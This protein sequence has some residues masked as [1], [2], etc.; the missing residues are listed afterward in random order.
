MFYTHRN[1]D[2]NKLVPSHANQIV[3]QDVKGEIWTREQGKSKFP[4]KKHNH[5]NIENNIVSSDISLADNLRL[6]TDPNH[7]NATL[8][9]NRN[10]LD[11]RWYYS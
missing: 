5:D 1:N 9:S 8:S 7:K 3:Q 11:D 2:L 6:S 10:S 4:I